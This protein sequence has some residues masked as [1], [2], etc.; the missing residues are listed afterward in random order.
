ML[1]W[2]VETLLVTRQKV[3]IEATYGKGLSYLSRFQRTEWHPEL[4]QV[5]ILKGYFVIPY[6]RNKRLQWR[7]LAEIQILIHKQFT[8]RDLRSCNPIVEMSIPSIKIRP[9]AG[10]A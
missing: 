10:S 6:L 2:N 9:L 5:Q 1:V 8:K 3:Y 7:L 4:Y